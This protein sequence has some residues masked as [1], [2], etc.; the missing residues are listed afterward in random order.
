MEKRLE[1]TKE[2]AIA[3]YVSI[4]GEL[5][6]REEKEKIIDLWMK[7]CPVNY[8]MLLTIQDKKDEFEQYMSKCYEHRRLYTGYC[9]GLEIE[10]Q[11]KRAQHI[12]KYGK[13]TI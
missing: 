5:G 7:R 2:N 9:A 11:R 12:L 10:I 13:T 3:S 1:Y 6:R 4:L 8:I